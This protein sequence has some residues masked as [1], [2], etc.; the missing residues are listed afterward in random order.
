MK[1]TIKLFAV[2]TIALLSFGTASAT[3]LMGG[4]IWVE[5]NTAGNHILKHKNFRD[6]LGIPAYAATDFVAF[7][8]NTT[9]SSWDPISAPSSMS[10]TMPMD[11]N[12]SGFL[13]QGV[14]YGVEIYNYSS[15]VGLL[16]SIFAAN[17][18]GRYRFYTNECCRNNAIQNLTVKTDMIIHCEYTYDNMSTNQSPRYLA[19]PIF[20]GPINNAWVYNP[21]PF[22]PD[23]DSL[24][25]AIDTPV[26]SANSSTG[27]YIYCGGYS[28]PPAATS[29][30]F[31]LNPVTGQLD[32]TP[33]MLGNFVAS[34]IVTEY[35]NGI[36]IGNS[37][38]D[39]QYI[40]VPDSN[41]N[42]PVAMPEFIPVTGYGVG[43]QNS[44]SSFNYQYYYPGSPM[45]FTVGAM[46]Q[47]NNDVLSM[48]AFSNLL[49][50]NNSNAAFSYMPTG[51]GNIVN[52]TFTW[53]PPANETRDQTVVIRASDG[54]FSKDFTI[55]LKKFE[56]PTAINDM[57]TKQMDITV[58]PNPAKA[59]SDISFKVVSQESMK[60][61]QLRI[62]DLTGKIVA[63]QEMKT[64]SAGV[65]SIQ[66]NQNLQAGFYLA[67]FI[68]AKE[69]KKQLIK[70]VVQ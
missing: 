24:A 64:I 33:S 44:S 29:G 32:W 4:D 25:W 46:D 3:H 22:D 1:N 27:A 56:A 13:I 2:L 21:L 51:N 28:T 8:W 48:S 36:E 70:F 14:Q 31:T 34:F 54:N 50:N 49:N 12:S 63:T 45:T 11:S 15:D 61:I 17:G 18:N 26:C 60:D 30:P 7:K 55:V 66:L 37:I 41:N 9:T 57:D 38:R 35:R 65:S 43:N 20:F 40:V 39:M 5:K 19:I 23:A 69:N 67:Q 52:G 16:D 59:N 68:D 10:L 62:V 42:G 6:T 58:Y 47:N 53:T